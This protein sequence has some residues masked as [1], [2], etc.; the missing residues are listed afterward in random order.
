MRVFTK[1]TKVIGVAKHELDALVDMIRE[2]G[3]TGKAERQMSETEYLAIE[4]G[5]IYDTHRPLAH[6]ER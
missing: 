1:H 2:A 6:K 5:D 3:T 4:V